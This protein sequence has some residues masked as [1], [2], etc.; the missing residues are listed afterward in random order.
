MTEAELR[1]SAIAL[2]QLLGYRVYFT[3]S[4]IHSPGGFPD[5]IAVREKPDRTA[6]MVALELKSERGKLTQAQKEWLALL[7]KV[8]GIRVGCF[9]PS[10]WEA[11]VEILKRA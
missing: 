5:I 11:I 6:E 10:E 1:K 2:A 3:W 8:P 4:S 7:A 9:K